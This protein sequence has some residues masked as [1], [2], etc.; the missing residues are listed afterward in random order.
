MCTRSAPLLSLHHARREG[1]EEVKEV[2]EIRDGG[3]VREVEGG[4]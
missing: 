3:R 4:R 2:K 1:R